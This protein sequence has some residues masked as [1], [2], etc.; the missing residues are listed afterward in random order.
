MVRQLV[1][2]K[3]PTVFGIGG[4][5]IFLSSWKYVVLMIIMQNEILHIQQSHST[6]AHCIWG[7]DGYWKA[8]KIQIT[9]YLTNSSR[10][11][12]SRLGQFVL[13]SINILIVWNKK[14]AITNCS[15][16]RDIS[17][18]QST[19]EILSN[20]LLSR[21]TP[22]WESSMWISTQHVNYW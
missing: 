3:T 7:L 6:L 19:Y 16:Y 14:G 5:I 13:R 4:G 10:I 11:D 9:R 15:N 21:L 2:L 8:R 20:I 18:L 12:E 17:L 22:Y 1:C